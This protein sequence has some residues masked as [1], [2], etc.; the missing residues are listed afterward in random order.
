MS[1][2]RDLYSSGEQKPIAIALTVFRIPGNSY[3]SFLLESVLLFLPLFHTHSLDKEKLQAHKQ[4]I[5]EYIQLYISLLHT[6][7]V[8][9]F[10]PRM[11]LYIA[12][13]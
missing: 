6:S 8:V 13:S 2:E 9:S 1:L 10:K 3:P 12:Y 5:C 11:H 7:V 4:S